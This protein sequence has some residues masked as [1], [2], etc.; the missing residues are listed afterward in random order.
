M[1]QISQ[2]KPALPKRFYTS[3]DMEECEDGFSIL[4]DGRKVK[5][6]GKLVLALP[7]EKLARALCEE[8]DAQETHIDPETMPLTK[9][10]NTALDRV[11]AHRAEIV[12]EIAGFGASDLLCYRA[13]HPDALIERQAEAWDPLLDWLEERFGA[14]L[15]ITSG[16]IFQ[17]QDGAHLARLH[18]TVDGM[19]RFGLAALHFAVSLTGSLVLGLAMAEAR[20]TAD[21]A[22]DL[23]HLDEAWQAEKWG[24]DKEAQDRLED[25]RQALLAAGRFMEL[26]DAATSSAA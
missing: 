6:P 8:W 9:L 23:A 14:R 17:E 24:W 15:A 22:H 11:A 12:G 1:T 10:A 25:R 21:E 19:D 7:G 3:V 2:D 26:L 5:T 18:E 4:L 16:V 20:L 13:T